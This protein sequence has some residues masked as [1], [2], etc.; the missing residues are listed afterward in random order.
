MEWVEKS[1]HLHGSYCLN[2]RQM[3]LYGQGLVSKNYHNFKCFLGCQLAG[4][5][6]RYFGHCL[7]GLDFL[8]GWKEIESLEGWTDDDSRLRSL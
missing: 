8:W 3:C 5:G 6:C 1:Q 2:F 7:G 4:R